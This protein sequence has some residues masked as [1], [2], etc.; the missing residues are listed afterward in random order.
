MQ[1]AVIEYARDVLGLSD[2]T[3]TEFDSFTNNPVIDLMA[4]QN[5]LVIWVVHLDLGIMSVLLKR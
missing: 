1:I 3:S 4:D 5:L 2:A